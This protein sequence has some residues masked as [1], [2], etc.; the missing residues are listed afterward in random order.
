MS[1]EKELIEV[2]IKYLNESLKRI[3][4]CYGELSENE[5]WVRPNDS[6]NSMGNLVLHLCGNITQ[7]IISSLGNSPDERKRDEEFQANGGQN[8]AQLLEKLKSVIHESNSIIRALREDQLLRKYHVQGFEM[9][10]VDILIHVV[11]HLSYHTGQI[12]FYTKELKDIDM[13]LYSGIDLNQ[14]NKQ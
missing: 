11:E 12:V 9:T 4:K 5:I 8:K 2:S 6:S 7:Y 14:K 10:G 3:N 13:G 1:L